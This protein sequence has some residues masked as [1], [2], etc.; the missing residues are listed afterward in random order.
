MENADKY[1]E[2]LELTAVKESNHTHLAEDIDFCISQV[3]YLCQG[4]FWC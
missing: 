1:A 4:P 2:C 3:D